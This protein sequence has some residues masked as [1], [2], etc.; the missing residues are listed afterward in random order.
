MKILEKFPIAL[1]VIPVI[2][3]MAWWNPFNWSALSFISD[4]EPKVE[5]VSIPTNDNATT[6]SQGRNFQNVPSTT[7]NEE[8]NELALPIKINQET[9]PLKQNQVLAPASQ[10][11]NLPPPTNISTESP[12]TPTEPI[13]DDQFCKD[14]YGK[15]SMWDTDT[16]NCTCA[17]GYLVSS[18]G[19]SCIS[20]SLY[21]NN[22]YGDNTIWDK[23]SLSCACAKGYES[24]ADG[25]S[26]VKV[27]DL[28]INESYCQTAKDN[29]L[30]F[31]NLYAGTIAG[32]R[33][34]GSDLSSKQAAE[35]D[36]TNRYN[37]GLPVYQLLVQAACTIPKSNT[38]C[39]IVITK[40]NG[41]FQK[42]MFVSNTYEYLQFGIYSNDI[43]YSC[44]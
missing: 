1:L 26:C 11:Q 35:A 6:S 15:N 38:N 17:S 30:K 14:S 2:A 31:Q 10:V 32:L 13:Y 36:Y 19:N 23:S 20:T 39:Q 18:D 22:V 34:T 29:L 27:P 42:N 24:S 4:R 40:Y 16:S 5:M 43:Y 37:T 28:S 7:V 44:Q 21:C 25:T 9:N 8:K 3:F 41:I 12:S 33:S